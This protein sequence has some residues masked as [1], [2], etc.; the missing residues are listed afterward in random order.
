MSAKEFD[1]GFTCIVISIEPGVQFAREN[2]VSQLTLSTY[3]KDYI[4]QAPKA[5]VQ[6]LVA[7]L[8]LQVLGLIFPLLSEFAIDQLIPAKMVNALQLFG[9]GLILLVLAQV[10]TR[11]LRALILLY[12]QSR[13]DI[14][15]MFNFLEHLLSPGL[16]ASIQ[17]V[18]CR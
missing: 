8:L 7:S 6:V 9:I 5:L 2:N 15:L 11:L 18:S 17:I 12:L 10:I 3:A 14:R 4:K 1:E 16:C 13:V